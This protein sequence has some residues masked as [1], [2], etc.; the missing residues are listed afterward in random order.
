MQIDSITPTRFD[1]G[2]S[3]TVTGEG[4]GSSQGQVLIGGIAQN[5]NTWSDTAITFTS[6]RGSQSMGACRVDVVAGSDVTL[7]LQARSMGQVVSNGGT[8]TIPRYAA[9]LF[10]LSG[11]TAAG[12]DTPF[13]QLFSHHDYG[14][15]T[16]TTPG[17][18]TQ[19][20]LPRGNDIGGLIRTHVYETAG[21]Y[22]YTVRVK[23]PSGG[24]AEGSITVVVE[25]PSD[26]FTNVVAIGGGSSWPTW[27]NDTLYTFSD[28]QDCTAK[29]NLDI[30][31]N[32]HDIWIMG[33]PAAPAIV[34]DNVGVM[35][36]INPGATSFTSPYNI[37]FV[38]ITGALEIGV[39]YGTD[40]TF[41]AVAG[42]NLTTAFISHRDVFGY[43]GTHFLRPSGVAFSK[44]NVTGTSTEG[45]PVYWCATGAEYVSLIDC[46][47]NQGT[48]TSH[49]GR[50]QGAY[51][52]VFSHSKFWGMGSDGA[53]LTIRSNGRDPWNRAYHLTVPDEQPTE[54]VVVANCTFG[55]NSDSLVSNFPTSV[56]LSESGVT[57]QGR[58]QDIVW[59]SNSYA[60]DIEAAGRSVLLSFLGRRLGVTDCTGLLA[61]KI[62]YNNETSVPGTV[63]ADYIPV[64]SED[65]FAQGFLAGERIQLPAF[66]DPGK[67]GS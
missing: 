2:R 18:H 33:N 44:C 64:Y 35:I 41:H 47:V 5:V 40:I 9:V 13:V 67:A 61:S 25:E 15:A 14:Y 12:I 51:K 43:S 1:N 11:T 7:S 6:V 45:A 56:M 17:S 62:S 59:I 54:F 52:T 3:V 30:P 48:Y 23:I 37:G 36:S 27:A 53:Y 31:Q 26:Y 50:T 39:N 58:L 63:R 21:T 60:T 20:G 16:P 65:G 66:E 24:Y 49:I 57:N 55:D 32:L 29:G 34:N 8:I 22:E 42:R 19:S 38:G 46:S 10:D 28:N 4:F